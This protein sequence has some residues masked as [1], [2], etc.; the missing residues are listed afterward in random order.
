MSAVTTADVASAV[1]AWVVDVI[2]TLSAST[3]DYHASRKSKP[4]PDAA[5]EIDDV[6]QGDTPQQVGMDEFHFAQVGWEQVI[7][8]SWA[9]RILLMTDE[10]PPGEA[11]DTLHGFADAIMDGLIA[12]RTMNGRV[13]WAGRSARASYTPPFV[14]YEDGARGRVVTLEVRVG[15]AVEVDD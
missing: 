15:A 12:S 10:D 8:R 13:Q 11:E 4:F 7:F 1:E 3:Y 5:I 2:P 14:E 9:V 6:T